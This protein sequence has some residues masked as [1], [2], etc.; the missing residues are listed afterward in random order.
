[1]V[2]SVR[3]E[4]EPGQILVVPDI[5]AGPFTTMAIVSE[6]TIEGDTQPVAVIRQ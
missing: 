1:M 4:I 2:A 6:K 5:G 3:L